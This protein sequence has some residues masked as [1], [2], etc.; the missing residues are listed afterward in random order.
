LCRKAAGTDEFALWHVQPSATYFCI[1]TKVGKNS[2][3]AFPL[4]KLPVV[5]KYLFVLLSTPPSRK[6]Y[7]F[8]PL[9]RYSVI[10]ANFLPLL[11]GAFHL[12]WSYGA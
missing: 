11:L 7:A 5:R 1:E 9:T 6:R 4:R 2:P 8:A 3:K 12:Q 10:N